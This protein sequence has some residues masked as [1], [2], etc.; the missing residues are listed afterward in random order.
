MRRA[1]FIESSRQV[2]KTY[3]RCELLNGP[4]RERTVLVLDLRV[5]ASTRFDLFRELWQGMANA[6]A[7][8]FR[9]RRVATKNGRARVGLPSAQVR[10]VSAR[11]A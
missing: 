10:S 6:P 1:G 8:H 11:Q 2:V 3:G 9:P 5:Y 7:N 4:T